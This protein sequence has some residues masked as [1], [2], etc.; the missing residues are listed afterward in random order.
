MR[1]Y[2]RPREVIVQCPGCLTFE[3]LWICGKKMDPS[4]KFYQDSKGIYH[5]CGCRL[6]CRIFPRFPGEWT[7]LL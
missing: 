3:T 4:R 1:S 2:P 5:D 7:R 6:P